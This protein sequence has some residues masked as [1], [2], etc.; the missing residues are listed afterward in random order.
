MRLIICDRL[1]EPAYGIFCENRVL[2]VFDKRANSP[3]SLRPIERF[4]LERARFVCDR[5]TRIE[6]EN[7]RSEGIAMYVYSVSV[8]YV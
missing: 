6:S 3:A 5:A 4:A 8:Y 2:C 7:L 1:W